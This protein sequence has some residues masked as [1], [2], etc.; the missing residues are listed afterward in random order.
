MAYDILPNEDLNE[1]IVMDILN[2]HGGNVKDSDDIFSENANVNA[3]SR[4]KP[5][6]YSKIHCQDYDQSRDDYDPTWWKGNSG[7]CG[8]AIPSYNSMDDVR[9][10]TNGTLNGWVYTLP[11]G[12]EMEPFRMGD[13]AGYSA[14]AE[15]PFKKFSIP[16]RVGQ[17]TTLKCQFEYNAAQLG[18]SSLT[19]EDFDAL[20]KCYLG[21]KI[22]NTVTNESYWNTTENTL[23]EGINYQVSI[24]ISVA[25]LDSNWVAFP[26]LCDKKQIQ[27][28]PMQ[29]NARYYALPKVDKA[30]FTIASSVDVL[31]VTAVYVYR[32]GGTITRDSILLPLYMK[33]KF[34]YKN[35]SGRATTNNY[36]LL[37]KEKTDTTPVL[38]QKLPD[39]SVAY[40]GTYNYPMDAT[41][42]EWAEIRDPDT[43]KVNWVTVSIRGGDVSETVQPVRQNVDR[44]LE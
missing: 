1:T 31:N 26:F 16:E 18:N 29:G 2:E 41:G 33:Y 39:F 43:S 12:G 38:S 30:T 7:N 28:E 35:F 13:F 14:I 20:K 17:G 36:V 15:A 25:K 22:Y 24:E 21:V 8:I 27:G 10:K 44:P 42:E 4:R 3:F 11:S 40:G 9:E 34:S 32:Q 37:K 5:V 6:P 19:L 23:E